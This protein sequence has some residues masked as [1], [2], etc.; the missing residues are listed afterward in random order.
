[1]RADTVF[2]AMVTGRTLTMCFTANSPR[3]AHF[4]ASASAM[5]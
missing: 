3:N 4:W 5:G 1:V 2:F